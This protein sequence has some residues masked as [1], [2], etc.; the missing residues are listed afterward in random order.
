[1][2]LCAIERRYSSATEQRKRHRLSGQYHPIES[3]VTKPE[4]LWRSMQFGSL[5]YCLLSRSG[6]QVFRVVC[7]DGGAVDGS[8]RSGMLSLACLFESHFSHAQAKSGRIFGERGKTI[9]LPLGPSF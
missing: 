6:E 5:A 3:A 8:S 4:I 9:A 1:M 2:C 7:R